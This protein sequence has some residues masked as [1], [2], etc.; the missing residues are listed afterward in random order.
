MGWCSLESYAEIYEHLNDL[1]WDGPLL[2]KSFAL[3]VPLMAPVIA[4][5]GV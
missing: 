3:H 4:S 5:A 2:P 1:D